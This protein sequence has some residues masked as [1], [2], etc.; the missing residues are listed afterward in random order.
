MQIL[1]T[2]FFAYAHGKIR[3]DH[4]HYAGIR[5]SAYVLFDS[6]VPTDVHLVCSVREFEQ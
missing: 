3:S 6:T 5:L 2:F 1:I 4:T